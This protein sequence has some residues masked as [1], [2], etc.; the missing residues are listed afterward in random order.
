MSHR[1]GAHQWIDGPDPVQ[2]VE[3]MAF[4]GWAGGVRGHQPC[5]RGHWV[6]GA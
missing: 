1:A 4:P 2:A 3:N 6:L 5:V